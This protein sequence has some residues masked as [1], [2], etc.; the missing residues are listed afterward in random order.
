ML[1]KLPVV[2]LLLAIVV[3]ASQLLYCAPTGKITG[4][5]TDATNNQPLLGANVIL[6]GTSMGAAADM[7]GN[8]TISNVPDG[9]YRLRTSY[10]GYKTETIN[11]QVKDGLELVENIK[12]EPVG[13]T[14]KEVVVTAQA[15]GQNA[16]I[17]QQLTSNKIVNV[18]SAARIQEL[19]DANAAESVG[20]LPGVSI[21]RSGGEGNGIVIRG[22]QPKY[23]TIMIDGVEMAATDAGDRG[24]DLSMISSNMLEGI[25]V[26]K[27]ATPDMDAAFLGGVVNFQ[28]REAKSNASH[29]PIIGLLA[30]GGYKGLQS[31][32]NDYKFVAS[33]EN[34]YFNDKFGIFAQGIVERVNLTDDELG[35][36]YELAN[37]TP[38]Y[39]LPNPIQ[40][41]SLNLTFNPRNR[42]RY[43]GTLVMDYKLPQGKIDFMNMFS[44]SNTSNESRG[45][46]YSIPSNSIDFG[47]GASTNI[48]NTMVNIIDYK[49]SLLSTDM[50]IRLSHSYSENVNPDSWSM[51]FSQISA[52]TGTIS[53]KL[54]PQQMAQASVKKINLNN[55]LFNGISTSNSFTRERDLT[56]SIDFKKE[57]N[58]SD[59]VTAIFKAGGQLHYTYRDY[60]YD[61]G[62]GTIYY[63]GNGDARAAILAAFP[64]MTQEPYNINPNGT[65]NLPITV[66]Q[67]PSFSYGNFL[68]GQYGMGPG[69]NLS[70]LKQAVEIVRNIG[71]GKPGAVSGDYSPDFLGSGI[72]DYSGKEY[73]S[74][75]Y[76]MGTFNLGPQF[77]IIPGVRFQG[78]TTVYEAPRYYNGSNAPMYPNPIPHQDTTMTEVHNYW[79]P[80]VNL[81]Y[82]PFTFMDVRL[83]YTNTLNY[84]DYSNLSPKM[85]IYT[86]SVT[87]NNFLLK[88]AKSQNYDAQISIHDNNLGLFT[89]GGF[90]K[91][92]DQLI[93]GTGKRYI[94]N[95]SAYP[96]VPS[97]AQ[98]YTISTQINNPFRANVWGLEFDWQTHF[99]YLPDP[100]KG[101]VMNINYT[102]IFS[103]AKYPV[104]IVRNTGYP[105]YHPI[106]VDTS[107]TAQLIDQP[108][109]DI[110]LSLGYDYQGFSTRVSMIYQANVYNGSSQVYQEFR[111]SK[112]TYIRWDFTAKQELPWFGVN[113]YLDINNL[114]G[115]N[116][117]YLIQGNG[118]PTSAQDYGL[119]ADLGFRW[120]LQ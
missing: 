22:L 114:N 32:A 16:A 88:P 91:Q 95:P 1:R 13:I 109:D 36:G 31:Q 42:H 120:R 74:A 73:R 55:L 68:N 58:F 82:R 93:F 47:E 28:L 87:W 37:R 85:V 100:L 8:F 33:V 104:T 3:T 12:L 99:W 25:E 19:P 49:Q 29:T 94:T 70:L 14:G 112:K 54:N 69:V 20:R 106:Y 97:Y 15:S 64:W 107:Y 44:Q 39:Y 56:G 92:I 90:L 102:H 35:A 103:S 110:N 78:L 111:S 115:E 9:S 18:V 24:T 53:P 48:L 108:Y 80:D 52:G 84:P 117:T 6:V 89:A 67:D 4:K 7:D 65:Q 2:S 59:F 71:I 26:F 5:V 98:D 75:G 72:N 63:P 11:V 62:G 79:L 27:T 34:R 81:I 23:N 10:I 76:I 45:Q 17:N 105:Y 40:I 86:N 77:T 38:S 96:G 113:V 50:D 46:S 57:I 30:Q 61:D 41:S 83:A 118:F 21:V 66:F 43:D 101:L 51:N 60:N 119:T 116:D